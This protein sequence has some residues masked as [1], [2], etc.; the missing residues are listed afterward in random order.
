[1]RNEMK[2]YLEEFFRLVE[3]PS[4][5]KSRFVDGCKTVPTM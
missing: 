2:S 1:M 4:S 5:I 3:K